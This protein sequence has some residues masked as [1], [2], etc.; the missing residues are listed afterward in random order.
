MSFEHLELVYIAKTYGLLYLIGFS[1]AVL[2][3]V[4]WPKNKTTFDKASKSIINDEDK[5]WV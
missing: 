4:Y 2:A 1:I 3:Y 5:P